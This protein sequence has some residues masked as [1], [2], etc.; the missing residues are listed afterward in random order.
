MEIYGAGSLEDIK[1]CTELGVAGILTNPQGFDVYFKGEMTLVE[2]TKAIL[3]VSDSP[4]FIQIHGK[5]HETIIHRARELRKIS[6][7]VNAKIIGDHKG[8]KAIKVLQ[9]EG[10]DCIAT[11]LF[12]Q[13][14]AAIAAMV[15]AYGICPFYSRAKDIGMDM[16][17]IIQ[18]IKDG[19]KSLD[20]PPKIF[21][22]SLKSV[23]DVNEVLAAGTDAIALRFPLIEK[24]M[25]H[26]LT[27]KAEALFIKNWEHV[28]EE[29]VSYFK[30][31]KFL[32][33]LAE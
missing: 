24:M 3:K 30:N 11:C 2:I 1:K 14:Q 26:V 5:D 25:T 8:F 18:N 7:R 33:G 27:E 31:D 22:V 32:T 13:S 21:A 16:I 15:G 9:E 4:V 6:D 10:I 17:K 29:D 20:N 28:K 12:S 19:Y 23:S